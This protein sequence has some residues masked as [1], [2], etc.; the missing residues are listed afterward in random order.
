MTQ[1]TSF[2]SEDIGYL[3]FFLMIRRPPRSTL[4]PYTTLFRSL[5]RIPVSLGGKGGERVDQPRPGV[6]RIDDVVH[7]A[8]RGREVRVGELLAILGLARL[9]GVVLVEDFHRA[10]RAHDGDLRR[11]PGDV[12]VPPH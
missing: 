12:V 7:V 5:R 1:V 4:F 8:A 10:L 11:R 6:T 9:G 2:V 3:S